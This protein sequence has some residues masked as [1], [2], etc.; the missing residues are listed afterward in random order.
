MR[1]LFLVLSLF[2]ITSCV[3]PQAF[4]PPGRTVNFS[5]YKAAKL[6]VVDSVNT[7]Y[8][9]EGIPMFEGL[10]RGRFQSLG[11]S[12]VEKDEDLRIEVN[13]TSFEP[14]SRATR[15]IVG[16]GAGRALFTY[17]AI[18]KERSG[19]VIAEFE[20]G[21]SYHGGELTL[22]ENSMF[23]TDE[24]IKMGMIQQ[25]VIQVGQFIKDN[26]LQVAAQPSTIT[27]ENNHIQMPH[28]SF[29][30]PLDKGWYL[31]K[32]GGQQELV[33][34]SKDINPFFVYAMRFTRNTI[35]D[36]RM[37]RAA[38]KEVADDF[39]NLEKTIM[40]EQGV[41]KGLYKLDDVKMTEETVGTMKFY[42]MEYWTHSRSQ[43]QLAFLYLFFPK[44][45]DNDQFVIAHYSVTMA[46]NAVPF[47]FH[48]EDFKSALRS[49]EVRTDGPS[50]V[51]PT[52]PGKTVASPLLQ[53]DILQFILGLDGGTD[54]QCKQRKIVNTE[55]LIAPASANSG[56][57]VERW[58]LDRC[59]KPIRYQVTMSPS[60]SGGTD[61]TVGPE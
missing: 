57:A 3:T 17:R 10:L 31:Q 36:E 37:K 53:R 1:T 24:E 33:V 54:E 26:S 39:R 44:E 12:V 56:T 20:G 25:S 49:L 30:V 48:I 18:F 22:K 40:I 50:T 58:T 60:P 59:G 28:Y 9:K 5:Q 38:A 15:L 6:V 32:I 21:K 45:V 52:L 27:N 19:T 23:M 47:E 46:P 16:F 2:L 11:F 8:S 43:K 34:V 13:I 7:P 61:F 51:P 42:V 29:T 4:I 55:I 14:G 35:F 41:K